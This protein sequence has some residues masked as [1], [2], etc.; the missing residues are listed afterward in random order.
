MESK[1]S[2]KANATNDF[3]LEHFSITHKENQQMHP[4]EK[5]ICEGEL[6]LL[7]GCFSEAMEFFDRANAFEETAD[8]W[9]RQGLALFEYGNEDGKEHALLLAAKKFKQAVKL[10]PHHFEAL[11]SWGSTLILLGERFE[12]FHYFLEAKEKYEKALQLKPDLGDLYWDYGIIWHQLGLQS[13]EAVDFQKA[14]QC[15]EKATLK[16]SF[17]PADFWIDFGCTALDV[18]TKINDVRQITKAIHCFK[19]AIACDE[20]C[21]VSWS[22][23]AEALQMLYEHSHDEDHFSQANEC[24]AAG[25]NICPE[26]ADHWIAWAKFLCQSARKHFDIK[27]LRACLDKCHRAYAF[28]AQRSDVLV[29]WAEALALLGQFTERIDLLYEAENK[30]VEALDLCEDNPETWYSYGMCLC[31]FGQYFQDSDYYFQAIEKFQEGLSIDR[32]SLKLWHA[33]GRTYVIAGS[34]SFETDCVEQSLKFFHK[35][36]HLGTSS[37]LHVDFAQALAKLGEMTHEKEYFEQAIYHFETGLS[38]Q[39]N[40]LYSHPDWLFAYASTLDDLGDFYD[41]EI[42]Y[43]KAIELF[44]HVLMVDPELPYAHH[45]LAQA[46]CHLGELSGVLDPF[47]RAIHHLRLALKHEEDNDFV[48]LDWGIA[49]INISQ[50]T[51]IITECDQFLQEAEQ[52]II[53]AAKLGNL[54]AYYQLSCLYSLM[55]KYD[56]AMVFLCKADQAKVLPPLDELLDDE[57]LEALRCT[58][59]F[60]EFLFHLENK[61]NFHEER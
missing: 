59:D 31:C 38:L 3:S 47:Y 23:L 40:V 15:F 32:T 42:Y 55:R 49:L 46:L 10:L 25:A 37:T 28:D 8:F 7:Q 11:H 44:T 53:Q 30:I 5:W 51:P 4:A 2:S 9:Y 22:H 6:K 45:K 19:Q 50:Y 43:L 39:K 57:W 12:K 48:I 58:S 60:R 14:I 21:F 34:M 16:S 1:T 56:K 33:L 26:D 61:S 29:I 13:E 41:E 54:Q 27:R 18:S 52:K 20:T 36:L 24:F 17:L 35:A